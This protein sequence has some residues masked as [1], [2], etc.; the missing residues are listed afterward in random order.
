[1]TLDSDLQE[2]FRQETRRTRRLERLS[3][4]M[5]VSPSSSPSDNTSAPQVKT[6]AKVS[7]AD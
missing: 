2:M 5:V 6:G 1:M 4:K 7:A 3:G